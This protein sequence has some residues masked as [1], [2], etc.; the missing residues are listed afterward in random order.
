[1]RKGAALCFNIMNKTSFLDVRSLGLVLTEGLPGDRNKPVIGSLIEKL[2]RNKQFC[3]LKISL[4][5]CS[6]LEDMQIC[7]N[8]VFKMFGKTCISC[9][10][11]GK[12]TK[13]R[14][15]PGAPCGPHLF[16]FSRFLAFFSF[17]FS[18]FFF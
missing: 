10:T 13:T 9:K 1:M 15:S 4:V 14:K 18:F 17:S 11:T 6:I 3:L 7:K 16:C 5:L 2:S 12:V 8:Q